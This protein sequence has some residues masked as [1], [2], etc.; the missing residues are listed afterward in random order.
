MPAW[1][2]VVDRHSLHNFEGG[3]AE[4]L[5]INNSVIVHD[6]CLHTRN[7]V[8]GGNSYQGETTDHYSL[9]DIAQSPH[10][11]RWTLPIQDFEVVTVESWIADGVAFSQRFGDCLTDRTTR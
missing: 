5:L 7:A 4:V 11:C 9:D 8:F 10:W 1:I 6:E 3:G 2:R